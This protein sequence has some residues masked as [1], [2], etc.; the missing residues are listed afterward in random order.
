VIATAWGWPPREMVGM[1]L[2]ELMDWE[3][4]AEAVLEAGGGR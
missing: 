4:R 1:G 3:A 2:A